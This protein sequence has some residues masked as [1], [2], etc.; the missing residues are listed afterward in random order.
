V[1]EMRTGTLLRIG[2]YIISAALYAALLWL[3][4][5]GL[6]IAPIIAGLI[7]GY[8]ATGKAEAFLAG[9]VVGGLALVAIQGASIGRALGIVAGIG[10]AVL[11]VLV[12]LYH[13]LTP[14][15]VSLAVEEFRKK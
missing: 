10:G 15:F 4:A 9:I 1:I 12:L 6:L 11:A 5:G 3:H 2:I 14:A 8:V 13:T 7:I